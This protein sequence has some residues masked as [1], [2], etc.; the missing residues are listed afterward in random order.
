MTGLA[1]WLVPLVLAVL[2]VL[3]ASAP[4]VQAVAR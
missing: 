2:L 3:G 1:G 4:L